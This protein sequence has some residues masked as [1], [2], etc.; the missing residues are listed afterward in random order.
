MQTVAQ[1][2]LVYRLTGSSFLL[3]VVG[4]IGQA[5]VLLVAPWGGILADRHDRRRVIMATQTLQMILAFLLAGLVLGGAVRIWHILVLS[6]LGGIINGIDI[7]CRQAFLSDMVGKENLMNAIALNSSLFNGARIVGP[8]VAGLL[9]GW[10]GEGW[11]FLINGV[12]FL[13]V[14][15]GLSFMRTR[16]AVGAASRASALAEFREGLD[17]VRGAAPIRALLMLLGLVSLIGLPYHVLMPIFADRVLGVGAEGLGIL[18][19]ATGIGAFLGALTMAA[20]GDVRGLG[21]WVAA[22]AAGF[23]VSLFLFSLSRSFWLS[24]FFLLPASFCMMIQISSSNT[25]IQSMV[26]D[27]LRGRVMSVYSMVFLGITPFGALLAGA[28]SEPLGAPTTAG[29]GALVCLVGAGFFALRVPTMRDEARELIRRQA[30]PS[31]PA[32]G[33]DGGLLE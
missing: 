21:H 9:V 1:A 31:Y 29:L 14:L 2:W 13:A 16:C 20:R 3:G 28:L 33:T 22:A 17:F 18:M 23:S 32:V 26:P 25:L 6:A 19:T 11:C 4:F 27:R 15:A 5:P 10:I 12:S 8:A 24:W 7:P 30:A